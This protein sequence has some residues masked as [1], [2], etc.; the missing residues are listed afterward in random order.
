MNGLAASF[1]LRAQGIQNIRQVDQQ[2]L[3]QTGPW[4][5]FARMEYLRSPKHL[6]GPSLNIPNLTYR[7]WWEA[8]NSEHRW[9]ALIPN[10]EAPEIKG[11]P[12]ALFRL[13]KKKKTS[14]TL[15]YRPLIDYNTRTL[16]TTI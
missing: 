4:L 6:T 7:A 5:T 12:Y 15:A 3:G 9:E 2:P 14:E 10:S 13:E 11:T 1:A 8:V 16:C